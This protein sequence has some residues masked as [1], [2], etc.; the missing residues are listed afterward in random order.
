MADLLQYFFNFSLGIL[1]IRSSKKLQNLEIK[2]HN[3]NTD[4]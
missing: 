2:N 4:S 3:I 1:G